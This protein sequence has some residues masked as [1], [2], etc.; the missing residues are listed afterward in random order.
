MDSLG[1]VGFM[2]VLVFSATGGYVWLRWGWTGVLVI[3]RYRE[4]VDSAVRHD[5]GM[6]VLQRSD[7]GQ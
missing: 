4:V 6:T 5:V 1:Y 3:W 7:H 2:V